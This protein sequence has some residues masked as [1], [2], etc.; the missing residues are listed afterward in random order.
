MN[1][2]QP[3]QDIVV[4]EATWSE[5]EWKKAR[6]QTM[7]VER[8]LKD[9]ADAFNSLIKRAA[10]TAMANGSP[11]FV[12]YT[13]ALANARRAIDDAQERL[14]LAI[15]LVSKQ[16]DALDQAKSE[17]E[18]FVRTV[19]AQTAAD[20]IYQYNIRQSE[21]IMDEILAAKR[22]IK[23]QEDRH[24]GSSPSKK[25]VTLFA[26]VLKRSKIANKELSR[27]SLMQKVVAVTYN[28]IAGSETNKATAP[29][30]K[31]NSQVAEFNEILAGLNEKLN[32]VTEGI[33]RVRNE[34]FGK[35]ARSYRSVDNAEKGF[36]AAEALKNTVMLELEVGRQTLV[37]LQAFE[38]PVAEHSLQQF[39]DIVVSA[40]RSGTN[41]DEVTSLMGSKR[42]SDELIS[43]VKHSDL[44]EYDLIAELHYSKEAEAILLNSEDNESPVAALR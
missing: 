1:N 15:S 23:L 21:R 7:A 6:A 30:G 10:G 39:T 19:Q 43:M 20:T 42:L 33:F 17:H 9:N 40:A 32:Q 29:W 44:E 41:E 38:H 24:Q 8:A 31:T 3:Q 37:S 22:G 18:T 4:T 34:R 14:Q 2:L 25:G 27:D 13:E 11:I 28:W 26:R 12:P 35:I 16:L 36:A 5:V